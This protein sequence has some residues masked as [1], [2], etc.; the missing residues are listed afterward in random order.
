MRL[1]KSGSKSLN[2]RPVGGVAFENQSSAQPLTTCW[3][4]AV[5][6]VKGVTGVPLIGGSGEVLLWRHDVEIRQR[7]SES[8]YKVREVRDEATRKRESHPDLMRLRPE[9]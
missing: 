7:T 6:G 9:A 3:G 5:K 4:G 1:T 2:L 8:D